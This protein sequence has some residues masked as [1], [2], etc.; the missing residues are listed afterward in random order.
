[1]GGVMGLHRHF[2]LKPGE[3]VLVIEDILTTGRSTSEVV[4][5]SAVYGAKIVGVAA[6]VD[7]STA[8]LPLKVPV[9]ALMT[10]PSKAVPPDMCDQC[11]RRVPLMSPEDDRTVGGGG[12]K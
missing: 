12:E 9:R 8:Q 2:R 7:R 10:I 1:M 6:I 11:E 4:T 5:L 3:R